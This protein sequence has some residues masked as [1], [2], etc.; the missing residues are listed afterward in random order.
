MGVTSKLTP[1]RRRISAT[2][3]ATSGG[4]EVVTDDVDRRDGLRPCG[5]R[6]AIHS[7]DPLLPVELGRLA[8]DR[9]G[10]AGGA[11]VPQELS[12]DQLSGLDRPALTLAGDPPPAERLVGPGREVEGLGESDPTAPVR[13]DLPLVEKEGLPAGGIDLTPFVVAEV[14]LEHGLMI[15]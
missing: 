10:R 15:V 4:G 1:A 8:E 14:V 6:A 12:Q 7:A 11:R 9:G 13:G 3:S 5:R 2:I